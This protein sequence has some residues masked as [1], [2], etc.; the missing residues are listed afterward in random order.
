MMEP[1]CHDVLSQCRGDRAGLFPTET[2]FRD[3]EVLCNLTQG[4]LLLNIDVYCHSELTHSGEDPYRI[5]YR[6]DN[7]RTVRLKRSSA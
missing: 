7:G 3:Y 4:S 1:H 2:L 5:A 6:A